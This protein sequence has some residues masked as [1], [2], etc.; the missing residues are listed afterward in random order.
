MRLMYKSIQFFKFEN[1][2][3]RQ[4]LEVGT[5]GKIHEITDK[6]K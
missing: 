1:K 2:A 3:L 5:T 4:D 6:A